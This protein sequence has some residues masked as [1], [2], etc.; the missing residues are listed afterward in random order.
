MTAYPTDA[1]EVQRGRTPTPRF[2][3]PIGEL[4]RVPRQVPIEPWISQIRPAAKPAF[5]NWPST[6]LVKTQA[7][8]GFSAAM[9]SSRR[10]PACGSVRR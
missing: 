3:P 9:P 1:P 10:K 6:L 2:R 8:C 7:P 5:A 4:R